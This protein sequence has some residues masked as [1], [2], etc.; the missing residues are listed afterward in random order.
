MKL[1]LLS[2]LGLVGVQASHEEMEKI[3]NNINFYNLRSQCWGE[4]NVNVYQ[5]GILKA[6][7]KCM[8]LAPAY[9]LVELLKPLINPFTTLPGA[10]NNPFQKLQ[11][12]QNLNQLTSLWRSKR[13]A[14]T[15]LLDADQNDFVEFLGDFSEFKQARHGHQDGKSD[16]CSH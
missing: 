6:Q 3:M 15:G 13:Q 1:L 14:T 16:L 10:V 11:S 4:D 5:L 9:D 8:Q 2:L 12:F 7:E